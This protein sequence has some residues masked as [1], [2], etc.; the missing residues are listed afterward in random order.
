MF[1]MF[2]TAH[3]SVH[4][5][6]LKSSPFR[7]VYYVPDHSNQRW[8]LYF[9]VEEQSAVSLL[10]CNISSQEDGLSWLL[11]FSRWENAEGAETTN[12][13]VSAL[14]LRAALL[15]F[16]PVV[17]KF[18]LATATNISFRHLSNKAEY[19]GKQM[20]AYDAF[21]DGVIAALNQAKGNGKLKADEVRVC[22]EVLLNFSMASGADIGALNGH[23]NG[24]AS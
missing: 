7:N 4:V 12:A 20:V 10:V 5:C 8:P 19:S 16:N 9:L 21:M 23:R 11:F 17:R 24:V 1:R 6:D 13:A 18:A 2:S 14:V 3:K 22:E 15:S